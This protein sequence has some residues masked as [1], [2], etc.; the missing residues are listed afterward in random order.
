MDQFTEEIIEDLRC[1]AVRWGLHGRRVCYIKISEEELQDVR[2]LQTEI[3]GIFDHYVEIIEYLNTAEQHYLKKSLI[4]SI[5]GG[6][7]TAAVNAWKKGAQLSL[8][9][10][11]D[12]P[13]QLKAPFYAAITG[14]DRTDDNIF[15]PTAETEQSGE[16]KSIFDD[17]DSLKITTSSGR[18]ALNWAAVFGKL[19]IVKKMVEN[20]AD[21]KKLTDGG[22]SILMDAAYG[23]N[24]EIVTYLHQ[25]KL[26]INHNDPD[27]VTA[28][29]WATQQG[30][31]SV[32]TYLIKNGASTEFEEK[33]GWNT[34]TEMVRSGR[35]DWIEKYLETKANVKEAVNYK[36]TDDIS[37]LHVACQ[38]N[39]SESVGIARL[40][41]EKGAD[42]NAKTK[43]FGST[44]LHFAAANGNVNMV[45]FL[46][47]RVENNN[48][49]TGIDV[50]DNN[51]ATPLFYAV[52]N[53]HFPVV[54]YLV[55]KGC[56]INAK[57]ESGKTPLIA[58]AIN[59]NARI[60]NYLLE[61][62]ADPNIWNQDKQWNALHYAAD[63]GNAYITDC[64]LADGRV[65]INDTVTPGWTALMLAARE[66][67]VA[68]TDRL[69]RANANASYTYGQDLDAL[70]IAHD[71]NKPGVVALLKQWAINRP[72]MTEA[73]LNQLQREN[74]I[75]RSDDG[76]VS[77]QDDRPL[78]SDDASF[79]RFEAITD[80]EKH[81]I[82]AFA[83]QKGIQIRIP[84]ERRKFRKTNLP[85]YQHHCLLAIEDTG[86]D[87]GQR[88]LFALYAPDADLVLLNWTNEAIYRVNENKEE[89]FDISSD[90]NTISYCRFFFHF[91]RGQLGRFLFLELSEA[92]KIA[93][94]EKAEEKD[95]AVVQAQLKP[96]QVIERLADRII[97]EGTC[98]FKNALF[99]TKILIAI[100]QTQVKDPGTG[101]DEQFAIGQLKLFDEQLLIEDLPVNVDDRRNSIFG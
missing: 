91:V 44:P 9:D 90:A 76:S 83:E 62:K 61:N 35:K 18:T 66:G 42:A 39:K 56:N 8:D 6:H 47:D 29:F 16:P 92:S 94:T 28:L 31:E 63:D 50:E 2:R 24:L 87:K 74:I 40:L 14:D 12:E 45:A 5:K 53:N 25:A 69:L 36:A 21:I 22:S 20:G 95:K 77:I 57:D 89:S 75:N 19:G 49:Q 58:A 68:I 100:Q 67:H 99:S 85:F 51:K 78:V 59:G 55:E 46:L 93:W 80:L 32:R 52:D 33:D 82:E 73:L 48:P 30:H 10:R 26:N 97:V 15:S 84:L 43:D 96:L 4:N 23:G 37:S 11:G 64:L 27:G 72:E 60:V 41:I 98:L 34:L 1:D 70:K 38:S 86:K 7:V 101:N 54:T 13:Y 79:L 65:N 17:S 3:P 71:N 88:E 81:E